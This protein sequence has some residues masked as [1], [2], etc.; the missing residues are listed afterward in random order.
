MLTFRKM[1]LN[2]NVLE[3]A[4]NLLQ[5]RLGNRE[6]ALGL[7]KAL[8][9]L[10]SIELNQCFGFDAK[11]VVGQLDAKTGWAGS[12]ALRVK[13]PPGKVG[14]ENVTT[15]VKYLRGIFPNMSV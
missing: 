7:E 1:S 15:L 6:V 9:A 11:T 4:Q 2:R 3:H 8:D 13:L 5:H 12:L 14:R 10:I